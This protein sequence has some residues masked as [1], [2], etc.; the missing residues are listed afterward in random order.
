[1]SI[2]MLRSVIAVIRFFNPGKN[3]PMPLWVGMQYAYAMAIGPT[4]PEKLDN[5]RYTGIKWE[6]IEDVV[7]QAFKA[8]K[9]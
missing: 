2:K 3:N 7:L 9:K 8:K 6:G 4:L 1:M 5:D